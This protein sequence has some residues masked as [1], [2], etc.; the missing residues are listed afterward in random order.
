[1]ALWCQ[2]FLRRLPIRSNNTTGLAF[3]SSLSRIRRPFKR[4]PWVP[5]EEEKSPNLQTPETTV[6]QLTVPGKSYTIPAPVTY[7]AD[8]KTFLQLF[9]HDYNLALTWFSIIN[10]T[11]FT[12]YGNT[13][14]IK[15]SFFLIFQLNF[16]QGS[17]GP[18]SSTSGTSC[19]NGR[20]TCRQGQNLWAASWPPHIS[21]PTAEAK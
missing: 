8:K 19:S 15:S 3:S 13:F 14:S 11:S 12:P 7:T 6:K 18:G 4:Q 21:S 5:K 16:F 20:R 10:Y 9:S 2:N 17:D 1:M